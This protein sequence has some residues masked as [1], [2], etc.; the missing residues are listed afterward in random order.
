MF[1][2]GKHRSS[3]RPLLEQL[4]SRL[5]LDADVPAALPMAPAAD[6]A[7]LPLADVPAE[8][9]EAVSSKATFC[10][11]VRGSTNY[12]ESTFIR[13]G[14][15]GDYTDYTQVSYVQ[16]DLADIPAGASITSASLKLHIQ[17]DVGGSGGRYVC[18]VESPSW[19]ENTITWNNGVIGTNRTRLR[20]RPGTPSPIW[21]I[22][23]DPVLDAGWQSWNVTDFVSK[24]VSGV[25]PNHGFY[26][27]S[28]SDYGLT[29]YDSDDAQLSLRPRL[30]IEYEVPP[31]YDFSADLVVW[32]PPD[33]LC[34]GNDFHFQ[35][36]VYERTFETIPDQF[37]VYLVI[38]EDEAIEPTDT[39]LQEWPV[40]DMMDMWTAWENARL[41]EQP[42]A[43]FPVR[44]TVYF[45]LFADAEYD[46]PETNEDNNT[47][48]EAKSVFPTSPRLAEFG[49]SVSPATVLPGGQLTLQYEI[50][51]PTDEPIS[52]GLGASIR[53]TGSGQEGWRY[54]QGHDE[55]EAVAPGTATYERSFDIAPDAEP[56]SYDVAWGLWETIDVHPMWDYLEKESQFEVGLVDPSILAELYG[57]PHPLEPAQLTYAGKTYTFA[58]H[59]KDGN[60][61]IVVPYETTTGVFTL[62]TAVRDPDLAAFLLRSYAFRKAYQVGSPSFSGVQVELED[63][64][65]ITD[66][67]DPWY[68]DATFVVSPVLG[69][70]MS[71]RLADNAV[72]G[73]FMNHI[74]SRA[75]PSL[76]VPASAPKEIIWSAIGGLIENLHV[77][78]KPDELKFAAAL[79]QEQSPSPYASAIL[80]WAGLATAEAEASLGLLKFGADYLRAL[81]KIVKTNSILDD[82]FTKWGDY[83]AQV[84][85]HQASGMDM[86]LR[87]FKA[88]LRRSIAEIGFKLL[89]EYI[90][91]KIG[92]GELEENMRAI[93][94]ITDVH[95]EAI[96]ALTEQM[97]RDAEELES[98]YAMPSD[99]AE[100]RTR[101][102]ELEKRYA[103]CRGVYLYGLLEE[104]TRSQYIRYR[105]ILESMPGPV[106]WCY[107]AS[108]PLVET[109]GTNVA[110]YEARREELQGA[111]ID[112]LGASSVAS[113]YAT[114]VSQTLQE[115]PRLSAVGVAAALDASW[116]VAAGTTASLELRFVNTLDAPITEAHVSV[117]S[118][119]EDGIVY[120]A[121]L[122]SATIPPQEEAVV[123]VSV[124]PPYDYYHQ[125]LLPTGNDNIPL[126]TKLPIT[127]EGTVAGETSYL[128][129]TAEICIAPRGHV[130]QI[131]TDRT[132]VPADATSV[133]VEFDVAH[134]TIEIPSVLV[135]VLNP[136]GRVC[137]FATVPTVNGHGGLRL[138]FAEEEYGPYGIS[139]ALMDE[140]DTVVSPWF[141]ASKVVYRVPP[142]EGNPKAVTRQGTRVFVPSEDLPVADRLVGSAGIMDAEVIATDAHELSV[143]V[144]LAQQG[145]SIILGVPEENQLLA[146]L[147]ATDPRIDFVPTREGNVKVQVLPNAFGGDQ[148]VAIVAGMRDR[149]VDLGISAFVAAWPEPVAPTDVMLDQDT[150]DEN[151]PV[152]TV[153]GHLLVVDPD[154][155]DTHTLTFVEGDGDRDNSS[156]VIEGDVLKTDERFDF[157]TG[158]L[159]DI[160][161]SAVDQNGLELQK[162]LTISVMD[163]NEE[164]TGVI[165]S[166]A[167]V[168]EN[169]PA[170]TEIGTLTT[171]DPDREDQHVYTLPAGLGDND[172]FYIDGDRVKTGK[173]FDYEAKSSY[174]VHI[175]STDAGGLSTLEVFPVGVIDV[176]ETAPTVQSVL[177][178]S[179]LW[180]SDFLT[181]VGGDGYVVPTGSDQLA[182]LPW[183][184]V[185]RVRI[186][187]SEDVVVGRDDLV[188]SGIS[189]GQYAIAHFDY[190]GPARMGTWTLANA[191]SA[192]RLTLALSDQVADAAGNALDGDWIDAQS[193]FPSGD[194]EAGGEFRLTLNVLPGDADQSGTV[195]CLD[196]ITLK[197][198]C[199]TASGAWFSQG[200]FSGDGSVG[201]DDFLCLRE[202]FGKH[203]AAPTPPSGH[204]A[205]PFLPGTGNWTV[206]PNGGF[207]MGDL[208]EW[209]R[210]STPSGGFEASD[211]QAAVGA[212]AAKAVA[213]AIGG[214]GFTLEST[215]VAVVEGR[216]Y[217]L[218]GFFH[219][220]DVSSGKLYIDL[221]DAPFEVNVLSESGLPGWQ[222]AWGTFTVTDEFESVIVRTVRGGPVTAGE[223]GYFDE[224]AVTPASQF[225]PPSV[226]EVDLA[227]GL[228]PSGVL[229]GDLDADGRLDLAKTEHGTDEATV[230]DGIGSGWIDADLLA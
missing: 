180:A 183:G 81:V 53:P 159:Y 142:V 70:A 191:V 141:S 20:R 34:W 71:K 227:A 9:F 92:F 57:A 175:R 144:T 230:S 162:A 62:D 154:E 152:G 125:L 201:R 22:F 17:G 58:Q 133:N 131:Q 151:S 187:F 179:T 87:D 130:L 21:K 52:V 117:E 140:N 55:Y 104:M 98:L 139:L 47:A 147:I 72:L 178:S 182:P 50:T 229:P 25:W 108:P 13:V 164:P 160:R 2:W 76:F 138:E 217:V 89:S 188:L 79:Y 221:T 207:E 157:E 93:G 83:E 177:G 120:A 210:R 156:F 68:V 69:A 150:V 109:L 111:F 100:N 225:L 61:T 95:F 94:A 215:P 118:G 193:S 122:D 67:N 211:D 145:D 75:L 163:V 4:E 220:E 174:V 1:C 155:G 208:S 112:Y 32:D 123:R 38:S 203:V 101:I 42:P 59:A 7:A 197:R 136:S 77:G 60:D 6:G 161:V 14:D 31:R 74:A 18:A 84:L 198:N 116:E 124:S 192:D 158:S 114:A 43:G 223:H 12:G 205:G 166:N 218:S 106:A 176:D 63:F 195:D 97:L 110:S 44:G 39:K 181:S 148:D 30:V 82:L 135:S 121:S 199:G 23:P 172:C 28:V 26:L 153:V 49:C 66:L 185:D 190:D 226:A 40:R 184:N 168:P 129:T 5:L 200:D 149:E 107:G 48:S 64:A 51:N 29:D 189:E 16:F 209:T 90:I 45:G 146:H 204:L 119:R 8:V 102:R 88:A 56:G 126:A 212:Q 96:H 206:V 24:W 173:S 33:G 3:D 80:T 132:L 65:A 86:Y 91:S 41:P 105:T 10:D 219:A 46:I 54:D 194:G 127:L 224:I 143:L 99:T 167:G 228:E 169:E 115:P 19:D 85:V 37:Q 113:I 213:S 214:E 27:G 78:L 196:Y 186:A 134:D 36:E 73:T 137:G 103:K 128:R 35:A 202:G 222:F 216:Q 165:L 15:Y 11:R 170:G 171:I